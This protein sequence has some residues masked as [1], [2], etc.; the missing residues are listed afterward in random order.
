MAA[1]ELLGSRPVAEERTAAELAT[2]ERPDAAA[3]DGVAELPVTVDDGMLAIKD[4]GAAA[5]V[6]PGPPCEPVHADRNAAVAATPEKKSLRLLGA[7]TQQ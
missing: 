1:V 7:T 3:P 5:L 6:D 4:A 2:L